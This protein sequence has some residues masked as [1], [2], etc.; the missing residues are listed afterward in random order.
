[1]EKRKYM[2]GYSKNIR[3]TTVSISVELHS[4]YVSSITEAKCV[5]MR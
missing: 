2:E 5:K 1:M 4:Y 3:P